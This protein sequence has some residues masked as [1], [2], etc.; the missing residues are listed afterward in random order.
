[1]PV[2]L[3]LGEEDR[4]TPPRETAERVRRALDSA[5]VE[6]TIRLVPGADHALMVKPSAGSSWLAERPAEGWVAWL[7]RWTGERAQ[8]AEPLRE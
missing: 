6:S 4:L 5:G 1:M 8:L 2:L 3:V 7:I